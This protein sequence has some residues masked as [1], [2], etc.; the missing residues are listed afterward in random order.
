[1]DNV[2]SAQP[3]GRSFLMLCPPHSSSQTQ[4]CERCASHSAT[5]VRQNLQ[6]NDGH[7]GQIDGVVLSLPYCH[8]WSEIP[9]L[10]NNFLEGTPVIRRPSQ[11]ELL[12]ALGFGFLE[13]QPDT[14]QLLRLV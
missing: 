7:I 13:N 1:M 11:S 12:C 2:E 10:A 14:F 9:L 6:F 5:L 3:S 4:T 8:R